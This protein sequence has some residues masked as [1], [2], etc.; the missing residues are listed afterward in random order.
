MDPI[1]R[2]RLYALFSIYP[3]LEYS[4]QCLH[5][6]PPSGPI[7][8]R[9]SNPDRWPDDKS[10]PKLSHPVSRI[11]VHRSHEGS[12]P[13]LRVHARECFGPN[14]QWLYCAERPSRPAWIAVDRLVYIGGTAR[15]FTCTKHMPC[16]RIHMP[17]PFG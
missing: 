13:A 7:H 8:H 2:T 5:H 3:V 9:N 14:R 6:N 15:C 16:I 11:P 4:A 10:H 12:D 1:I 17:S